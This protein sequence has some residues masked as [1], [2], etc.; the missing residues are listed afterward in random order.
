MRSLLVIQALVIL[1]AIVGAYILL[2]EAALLPAAYGGAIALA[3]TLMLSGRM[4]K[5]DEISKTDPQRGVYSLYFGVVQR[6]IF[7]LVALGFGLGY[8][9][10]DPPAVL[11][12]FMFSQ[13]AHFLANMHNA[14]Q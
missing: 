2:G 11:G 14:K 10:L 12:V 1:V 6:F 5:V 7:V 13:L 9:K 4:V 3:N 8:L